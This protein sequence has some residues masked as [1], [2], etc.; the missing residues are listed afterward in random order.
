M[1]FLTGNIEVLYSDWHSL[2]KPNFMN[3]SINSSNPFLASNLIGYCLSLTGLA[4]GFN[5]MTT[6]SSTQ[7]CSGVPE[8]HTR[9]VTAFSTSLGISCNSASFCNIKT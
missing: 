1:H 4:S 5:W 3:C 6:G 9:G 8:A 7:D 2:N